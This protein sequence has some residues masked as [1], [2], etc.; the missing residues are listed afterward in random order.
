MYLIAK[1]KTHPQH[2]VNITDMKITGENCNIIIII[3]NNNNSWYVQYD[4]QSHDIQ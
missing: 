2:E 3:E 1:N 4:G